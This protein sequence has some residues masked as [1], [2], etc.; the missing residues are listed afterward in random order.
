MEEDGVGGAPCGII[1]HPELFYDL[2]RTE[3]PDRWNALPGSDGTRRL[4]K[5]RRTAL[6]ALLAPHIRLAHYEEG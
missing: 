6:L 4:R 1:M 2:W 3:H 5:K